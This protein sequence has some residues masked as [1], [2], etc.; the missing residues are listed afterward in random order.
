MYVAN[1]SQKNTFSRVVVTSSSFL[2]CSATTTPFLPHLGSLT[3]PLHT[4]ATHLCGGRTTRHFQINLHSPAEYLSH[5]LW[6]TYFT[7]CFGHV[8][9]C[10][11]F[12]FQKCIILFH[13]C[14]DINLSPSLSDFICLFSISRKLHC[15]RRSCELQ[16]C[17]RMSV[18]PDFWSRISRTRE[19]CRNTRWVH[20]RG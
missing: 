1:H 9:F 10:I 5:D 14:F 20:T 19:C 18:K 8:D 15:Y 2:E 16:R 13:I 6:H 11:T 17:V 3:D 7:L 12:I 4:S